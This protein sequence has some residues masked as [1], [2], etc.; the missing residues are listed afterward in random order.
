LHTHDPHF[1]G[2][3][4]WSNRRDSLVTIENRLSLASGRLP[5]RLK[6]Q[7]SFLE[8]LF[9]EAPLIENDPF[10]AAV[11]LVL[12]QAKHDVN[13]LAEI[14][15]ARLTYFGLRVAQ[16]LKNLSVQ[17]PSPRE[18][19]ISVPIFSSRTWARVV[20]S[21]DSLPLLNQFFLNPLSEEGWGHG[22]HVHYLGALL[23]PYFFSTMII[24]R[25]LN[26]AKGRAIQAQI[27]ADILPAAYFSCREIVLN[28]T[29]KDFALNKKIENVLNQLRECDSDARD[30]LAKAESEKGE[31]RDEY[32]KEG[33]IICLVYWAF[34]GAWEL[35]GLR[36]L[37]EP[38]EAFD[39]YLYG[40]RRAPLT[41]AL[42]TTKEYYPDIHKKAVNLEFWKE[43]CLG[44]RGA[45]TKHFGLL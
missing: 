5:L 10:D 28:I 2:K 18:K 21:R 3:Y 25:I 38:K 40:E 13:F 26:P 45:A 43:L 11:K 37:R 32:K 27:F 17:G 6:I 9:P 20:I 44:E 4:K 39:Q 7:R 1:G 19:I 14:G 30:L 23:L 8:I 12:E 34:Y 42:N 29:V 35:H 22:D 36:G 15:T 31:Y 41:S 33:T 16:H 24:K